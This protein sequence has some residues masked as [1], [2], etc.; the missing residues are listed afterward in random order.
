MIS[1]ETIY[2]LQQDIEVPEIVTKK[3]NETFEQ[4][5]MNSAANNKQ[6]SYMKS[7][8]NR[9]KRYAVIALA[10]STCFCWLISSAFTGS[11]TGDRN[12]NSLRCICRME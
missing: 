8:K 9:K 3:A 6:V 1:N 10:A 5:R 11:D 2:R 7:K 12:R 4:I